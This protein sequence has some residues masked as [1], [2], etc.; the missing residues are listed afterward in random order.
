MMVS[1]LG[2]IRFIR[3][4]F[5]VAVRFIF[6]RALAV[7]FFAVTDPKDLDG[8]GAFPIEE[9]AVITA[10]EPEPSKRRLQPFYVA[11]AVS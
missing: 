3:Q 7:S 2:L 5:G 6:E 10:A 1:T 9:D 8:F 11:G 4:D